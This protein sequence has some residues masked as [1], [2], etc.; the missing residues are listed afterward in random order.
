MGDRDLAPIQHPERLLVPTSREVTQASRE[1]L[2][3]LISRLE[4]SLVPGSREDAAKAAT[5]LVGCFK[6]PSTIASP[7][8]FVKELVNVLEPYPPDIFD[9]VRGK[10]VRECE[11]VPSIAEVNREC[12]AMTRPREEA[13]A[14]AKQIRAQHIQQ[15]Q[16]DQESKRREQEKRQREEDYRRRILTKAYRDACWAINTIFDN[17]STEAAYWD[18]ALRAGHPW[19][20]IALD[21]MAS[22]AA[23]CHKSSAYQEIEQ[24]YR[25]IRRSGNVRPRR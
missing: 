6:V 7:E 4:A 15:E 19:A 5:L 23:V 24:R 14:S 22:K 1:R 17:E 8:L 10:L 18:E 20:V 13:L 16:R 3:A 2:P 9:K 12:R 25:A 21:Y 11:W